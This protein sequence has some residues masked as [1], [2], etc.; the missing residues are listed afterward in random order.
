[1]WQIYYSYVQYSSFPTASI[2]GSGLTILDGTGEAVAEAHD[3]LVMFDFRQ[4]A[5]LP[6][7]EL[8]REKM[9]QAGAVA[10]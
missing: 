8:F 7:P 6:V 1:M 2:A 10:G 3:V 9:L 5:K 4:H